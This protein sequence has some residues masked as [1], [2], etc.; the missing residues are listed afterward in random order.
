MAVA[1]DGSVLKGV[2]AGDVPVINVASV[3]GSGR[4]GRG[5]ARQLVAVAA[6]A[7]ASLRARIE[8]VRYL[9]AKG[10]VAYLESGPQVILG[11]AGNL[12]GKWAAAAAILA[13]EESRGASYVDVS[14]PDRPVA[15]G[16]DVPQPEPE[17][18]PA[19]T[20]ATPAP[21]AAPA[22]PGGAASPATPGATPAPGAATPPGAT[23]AQP[24][25]AAPAATAPQPSTTP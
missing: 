3:P 16:V 15:G 14:L 13:D 11:D 12:A 18:P 21:G 5:R 20:G 10:L 25:P 4:L 19:G 7:P 17:Q 24:A 22:A 9:S 8:R 1:G 6:A 2:R 23:Q